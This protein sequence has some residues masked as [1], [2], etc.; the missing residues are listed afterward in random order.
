MHEN[1]RFKYPITQI[2][3]KTILQLLSTHT[4][5]F[6]GAYFHLACVPK[7][8]HNANVNVNSVLPIATYHYPSGDGL[9]A[10]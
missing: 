3:T 8:A 7:Y 5:N 2:N 4:L 9:V 10:G 1:C 6:D